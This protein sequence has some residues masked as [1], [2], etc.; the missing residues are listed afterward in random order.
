MITGLI[1]FYILS[2]FFHVPKAEPGPPETME[3]IVELE[4]FEEGPDQ[5]DKYS[6]SRLT[7]VKLPRSSPG[8]SSQTEFRPRQKRLKAPP[9]KRVSGSRIQIS[10][11]DRQKQLR[12]ELTNRGYT[13]PKFLRYQTLGLD[14]QPF[15]DSKPVIKQLIRA[16]RFQD[17]LDHL[18]RV[19]YETDEENLQVRSGIL[20]KIIEVSL[21]GGDMK[22]FE[23][24]SVRYYQVLEET[25]DIFR[26]SRLMDFHA[27][28]ERIYELSRALEM[29]KKGSMLQFLRALKS[30]KATPLEIVTG[31]KVVSQNKRSAPDSKIQITDSKL[32]EATGAAMKLFK[33]FQ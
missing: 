30:G 7:P 23:N 24:Y 22:S 11:E 31:L 5:P 33:Q 3:G 16:E 9:S 25:L 1:F 6:F 21:M 12:Q 15:R 20:E 8:Y 10:L 19:L 26:E 18:D 29:G 32:N 4:E 13:N 14:D 28:R 2:L 27:A 17:A